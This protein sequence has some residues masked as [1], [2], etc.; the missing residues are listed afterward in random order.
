MDI[1]QD[2]P[3]PLSHITITDEVIAYMDK[4]GGD[5]RIGTSCRGPALMPVRVQ[6]AKPTDI[7]FKAGD[8]IIFISRYQ[9]QWITEINIRLVHRIFYSENDGL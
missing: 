2:G 6:P 3:R 4:C 7:P 1:Q 8:H 9:V 5:F